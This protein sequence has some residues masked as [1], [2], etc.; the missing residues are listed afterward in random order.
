[1]GGATYSL[2]I[3]LLGCNTHLTATKRHAILTSHLYVPICYDD[4]LFHFKNLG[5]VQ[6]YV[7]CFTVLLSP[8]LDK[9][10]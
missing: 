8:V 3:A 5:K 6:D 10:D 1:M 2:G 4:L 7:L 9:N